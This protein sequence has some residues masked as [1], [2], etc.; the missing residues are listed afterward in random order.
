MNAYLL[1]IYLGLS[2]SLLLLLRGLLLF[3][4]QYPLSSYSVPLYGLKFAFFFFGYMFISESYS[5]W[6]IFNYLYIPATSAFGY[7]V[8]HFYFYIFRDRRRRKRSHWIGLLPAFFSIAILTGSEH[9]NFPLPDRP[10]TI[11]KGSET[12]WTD[13]LFRASSVV[14]LYFY[15]SIFADS[16]LLFRTSKNEKGKKVRKGLIALWIGL[17]INLILCSAFYLGNQTVLKLGL[18]ALTIQCALAFASLDSINLWKEIYEMS[19]RSADRIRR[20][21]SYKTISLSDSLDHA[22][23]VDRIYQKER[24]TIEDLAKHLKV[25]VRQLSQFINE[26]NRQNFSQYINGKRIEYVLL[27]LESESKPNLLRIA[28]DAGF[29]SKSSF[30][31]IFKLELGMSPSEYIKSKRKIQVR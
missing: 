10:D 19:K 6:R 13:W 5:Q 9:F 1:F 25:T 2:L 18:T 20:F 7:I 28:L 14:L 11:F 12:V 31:W 23:Y 26:E 22:I 4:N 8:Y 21:T 30:N 16:I 29:N 27:R 17:S 3:K 24:L 15:A